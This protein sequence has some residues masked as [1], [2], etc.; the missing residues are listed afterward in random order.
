MKRRSLEHGR[1]GRPCNQRTEYHHLVRAH[2]PI[3]SDRPDRQHALQQSSNP[4]QAA[5]P[6]STRPSGS[7]PLHVDP[8]EKKEGVTYGILWAACGA[9][10]PG[11][12]QY[13]RWKAV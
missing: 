3:S 12:R 4:S 10:D 5:P 13:D 7:E 8:L 6:P 11:H 1:G 2:E 9:R